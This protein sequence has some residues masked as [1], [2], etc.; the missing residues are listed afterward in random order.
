MAKP[1]TRSS[2]MIKIIRTNDIDNDNSKTN[3]TTR[4]CLEKLKQM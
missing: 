4:I 3:A 1:F 2:K